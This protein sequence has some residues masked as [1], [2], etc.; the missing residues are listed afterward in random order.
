MKDNMSY[1]VDN[2]T[3]IITVCAYCHPGTTVFDHVPELAAMRE[4]HRLSHGCCKRCGN[5]LKIA[6]VKLAL[7]RL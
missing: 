5:R 2:E 4:T 6:A 1:G 7:G 3:N